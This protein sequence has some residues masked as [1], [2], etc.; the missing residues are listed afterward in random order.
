MAKNTDPM[1][2][3]ADTPTALNDAAPV[4]KAGAEVVPL[5]CMAGVAEG[6]EDP[7]AT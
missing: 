5:C 6:A 1:P 2:M 3:T 7:E 4:Y